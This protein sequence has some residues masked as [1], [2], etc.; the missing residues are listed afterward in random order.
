MGAKAFFMFWII[1][2]SPGG[3]YG[4]DMYRYPD[5]VA[6]EKVRWINKELN[7]EIPGFNIAERCIEIHMPQT[8]A[9]MQRE[10]E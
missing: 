9:P 2:V 7:S 8:Q 1:I 3:E 6:C 5:Q 10:T 4:G